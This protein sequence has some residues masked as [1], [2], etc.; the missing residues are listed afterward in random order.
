MINQYSK[1]YQYFYFI[2]IYTFLNHKNSVEDGNYLIHKSLHIVDW[3]LNIITL[4]K[5]G[6]AYQILYDENLRAAYDRG[7]KSEVEKGAQM[8]SATLFAMIFGS[9]KFIPLGQLSYLRLS[10]TF[11]FTSWEI[12]IY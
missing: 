2:L 7:G 12:I 1:I 10:T 6:Q 8:D 11:Q 5:V 9:E 3:F 4:Q